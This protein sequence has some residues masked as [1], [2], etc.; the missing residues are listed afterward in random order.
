MATA[1]ETGRTVKI[2]FSARAMQTGAMAAA[3]TLAHPSAKPGDSRD[4]A[5]QI[6]AITDVPTDVT[7][8]EVIRRWNETVDLTW[9]GRSPGTGRHTFAYAE[10]G[11]GRMIF[12]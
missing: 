9:L 3:S 4:C 5:I 10:I 6:T 11:H 7:D 1:T 2:K 8:R 12:T